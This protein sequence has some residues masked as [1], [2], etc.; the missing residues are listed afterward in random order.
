MSST[1]LILWSVHSDFV[2]LI[3]FRVS[4]IEFLNVYVRTQMVSTKKCT[5]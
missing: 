1:N 5:L 2:L 3:S 4:I